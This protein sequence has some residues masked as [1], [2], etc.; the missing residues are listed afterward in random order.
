MCT[1]VEPFTKNAGS[2]RGRTRN[3]PVR[4]A[5][6]THDPPLGTASYEGGDTDCKSA[7][8]VAKD[9]IGRIIRV[10]DRNRNTYELAIDEHLA[11]PGAALRSLRLLDIDRRPF[12]DGPTHLVE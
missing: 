4:S 3:N 10:A 9:A 7:T 6:C 8:G 1:V 11:R 12:L 5:G 2:P